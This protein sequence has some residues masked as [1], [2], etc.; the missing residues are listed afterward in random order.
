M[1]EKEEKKRP[2]T[3]DDKVHTW[4][5][6]VRL[7][8]IVA[9]FVFVV[10]VLWS[11]G[12]DAPLEEP[13]NP[14][15][16]PN[17]SKAP[18]YFLGL[19]EMLVYFD[20]WLAGVV[21]PTLIIIGLMIIPFIDINPAGN[22]YYCFKERKYEVLTFFF[23][24]HILWVSMIIIGTFFRGPGWNLFWP[25]QRW[26]PHKVVALTNVDL[27][28]LLGFRDYGWSAVCGAVVVLGYFVVGL[29]GFYLWVLRVKGKEF[30]ERWGLVRF[31]ITAF[32]FVT[33]LSLPAKMFLRLAFNVKYILVTPWFN[34]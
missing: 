27:P 3:V 5:H 2:P 26:D 9:I 4:P 14:T 1:A 24:F 18:W 6:L 32:L 19:Q 10:L 31:L 29:A 17:P 33:M 22:G 34:I 25:W 12:I 15:R 30:L 16:T 28:Y 11:V 7:E 21:L 20:P 23:G 8:F 13:A